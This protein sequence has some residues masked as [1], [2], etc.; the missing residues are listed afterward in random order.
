MG[1]QQ[2]KTVRSLLVRITCALQPE[3]DFGALAQ[4]LRRALSLPLHSPEACFVWDLAL[5]GRINKLVDDLVHPMTISRVVPGSA[6]VIARSLPTSALNKVDFPEFVG[7]ASTTLGGTRTG[8]TACESRSSSTSPP[9]AASS[10]RRAN[11]S[12]R[13]ERAPST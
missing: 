1:L 3:D 9:C 6:Q 11:S 13:R 8:A 5:P 10:S 12:R 4:S 7:P 2:L